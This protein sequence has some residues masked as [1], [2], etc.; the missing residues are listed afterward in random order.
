[1][2]YLFTMSIEM[3]YL[4]IDPQYMLEPCLLSWGKI[5]QLFSKA[6]ISKIEKLNDYHRLYCIII[7]MSQRPKYELFLLTILSD[8]YNVHRSF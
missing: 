1:M 5:L 8:L 7:I 4:A 2:K 6:F 3:S